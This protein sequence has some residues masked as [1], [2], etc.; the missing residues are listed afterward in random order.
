MRISMKCVICWLC[1]GAQMIHFCQDPQFRWFCKQGQL[2]TLGEVQGFL[3]IAFTDALR[4]NIL[5]KT[6]PV[7][8]NMTT[9]DVCEL[10]LLASVACFCWSWVLCLNC[11]SLLALP[12]FAG[13][14]SFCLSCLSMLELPLFACLITSQCLLDGNPHSFPALLLYYPTVDCKWMSDLPTFHQPVMYQLVMQFVTDQWCTNLP[15]TNDVPICHWSMSDL[16]STNDLWNCH[17]GVICKG[18]C[19]GPVYELGK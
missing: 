17:W 15:L 8:P 1:C 16:S 13:V 12:V 5:W 3:K 6:L 9:K 10:L 18:I 11:L 2:P 14:G 4:D 19:Y 7:R